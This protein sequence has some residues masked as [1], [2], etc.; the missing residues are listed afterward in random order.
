ML[1]LWTLSVVLNF[2]VLSMPKEVSH[3]NMLCPRNPVVAVS[4]C[5]NPSYDSSK[6]LHDFG[7]TS[8][9]S[10][11]LDLQ[12]QQRVREREKIIQS[13]GSKTMLCITPYV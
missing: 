12:V 3:M 10:G 2:W 5:S 7:S 8:M 9:T 4:S 1:L 11:H 6:D 13:P